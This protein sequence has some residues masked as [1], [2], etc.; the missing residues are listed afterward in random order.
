MHS[1]WIAFGDDESTFA[2]GLNQSLFF[3]ALRIGSY[4]DVPTNFI[5]AKQHM[6]SAPAGLDYRQTFNDR[7]NL[8][9]PRFEQT[10]V[11]KIENF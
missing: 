1:T 10:A 11:I 9:S 5:A 4:L 6:P 8:L 3:S 2:F 7:F